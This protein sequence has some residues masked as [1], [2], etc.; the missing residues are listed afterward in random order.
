M[1]EEILKK[2]FI[3][4]QKRCTAIHE[5]KVELFKKRYSGTTKTD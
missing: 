1:K 5:I 4:T 2:N 3:R